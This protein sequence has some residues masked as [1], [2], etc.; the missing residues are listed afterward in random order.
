MIREIT[1]RK[2]SPFLSVPFLSFEEV[3]VISENLHKKK[4][5]KVYVVD[6]NSDMEA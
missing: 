3:L 1:R 4:V 5:E 6:V 2:F